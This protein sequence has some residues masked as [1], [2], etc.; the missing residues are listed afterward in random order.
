M[1]VGPINQPCSSLFVFST[2]I[3]TW[4]TPELSEPL[5][6]YVGYDYDVISGKVR[7]VRYRPEQTDALRHRYRYDHDGRVRSVE[8]SVD[9]YVWDR[10]AAYEYSAHGSLKRLELGRDSVQGMDYTYTVSGWLKAINHGSL[11]LALD[12]AKD[13]HSDGRKHFGRDAFGMALGYHDADFAHAG[14]TQNSIAGAGASWHVEPQA[15]LYNGNIA[16]WQW[17]TRS[18]EGLGMPLASRYRYDVLN[19]LRTDS[20]MIRQAAS[21]TSTPNY[22]SSYT[23]DGN[24]N[25]KSLVRVDSAGTLMDSLIYHYQTNKNRLTHVDDPGG[26]A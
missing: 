10:Q 23:Y 18:P 12:P 4:S 15:G 5:L 9:G 3:W 20:L 2:K 16:T 1:L 17:S 7:Q 24:G 6:A 25:I 13:G 8:T 19:R 11:D 26:V 21:W 14:S 22:R